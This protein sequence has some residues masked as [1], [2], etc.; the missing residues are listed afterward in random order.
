M[1]KFGH[2]VRQAAASLVLIGAVLGSYAARADQI[3]TDSHMLTGTSVIS[4]V[5]YTFTL[6][7]PGTLS[8][9]LKDQS[10]PTSS[11]TDL[12]FS[13]FN[14][15]NPMTL[16]GQF[17]GAGTASYNITGG[18]TIFA[19]VTGEATNSGTG[20]AY[21]VGLFT[22]DINFIPAVVPLPP[23]I[24]L[25]LIALVGFALLQRRTISRA[26]FSK[27]HPLSV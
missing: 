16:I 18:S 23:S 1:T 9:T 20:P 26:L 4:D 3:L 17:D 5:G 12:S 24:G 19:Y 27:A 11:L 21:G 8:V 7:G 2:Y 6:S 14:V 22:L 15:G 25:L 13:A 10:W